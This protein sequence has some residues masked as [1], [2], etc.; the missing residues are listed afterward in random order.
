MYSLINLLIKEPR[1]LLSTS[2]Q[3]S[4][5]TFD[6]LNGVYKLEKVCITINENSTIFSIKQH[7]NKGLNIPSDYSIYG[8]DYKDI[9]ELINIIKRQVEESI[10]SYENRKKTEEEKKKEEFKGFRPSY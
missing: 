2:V 6:N 3:L 5:L 7:I 10:L 9:N 8:G 4:L 1:V